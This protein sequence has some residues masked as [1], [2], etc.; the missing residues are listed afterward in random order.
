MARMVGFA[1]AVSSRNISGLGLGL[2]IAQE[3][4]QAHGGAISVVSILGDG[5][6]F[7]VKPPIE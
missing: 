5:S 7:T 1:R 4:V 2:H 6:T 3:I